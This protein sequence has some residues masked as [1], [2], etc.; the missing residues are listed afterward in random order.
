[1]KEFSK[2]G[3]QLDYFQKLEGK[4]FL[5]FGVEVWEEDDL[6]VCNGVQVKVFVREKQKELICEEGVCELVIWEVIQRV[7]GMSYVK[8]WFQSQVES[9]KV[10]VK[11]VM[12][13]V[14]RG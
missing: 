13:G 14:V 3:M 12:F 2:D 1:M 11:Y 9:W 6:E 4:E 8:L 10:F 7:V 5:V